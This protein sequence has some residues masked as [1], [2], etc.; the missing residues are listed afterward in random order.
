MRR[1]KTSYYQEV[2]IPI[3]VILYKRN[4][5]ETAQ[6]SFLER[7]LK[8][9]YCLVLVFSLV[10]AQSLLF[11]GFEAHIINVTAHIC[12]Y[13]ETRTMGYWKNHPNVY[14]PLLPQFLV[15]PSGNET[16][17]TQQKVNQVFL[18]YHLS[19]RSK[20]RGQ[21]LAM[22]FNIA[23]FGFG[24]YFDESEDK[25]LNQ[26]VADA[27]NLL[28]DQDTPDSVLEGMKNLLDYLNDL[29]QIKFCSSGNAGSNDDL[30]GNADN[31]DNSDPWN[32]NDPQGNTGNV[33][34]D[35]VINEF[36]PNPVGR[37]NELKPSGEW[38]ELYNKGN[39]IDVAGWVLYDAK[40]NHKLPITGENTNTGF[41]T[42]G[43]GEFLIVYRNGDSDFTLNNVG[44]DTARL[45]N[46]EITKGASLMDSHTYIIDAPEG[47]SFA[48]IPDGSDN[49][50]D[51][52]PTPGEPNILGSKDIVFGPAL[53]EP[54]E[55]TNEEIK[56]E[57]I[58]S[59]EI[60]GSGQAIENSSDNQDTLSPVAEPPTIEATSTVEDK[61][62]A[63]ETQAVDNNSPSTEETSAIEEQP[64]IEQEPVTEPDTNA[65]ES[66][67][68]ETVDGATQENIVV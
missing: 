11:S 57:T 28:L 38:V 60:I 36:L 48:R 61:P 2:K 18:D 32:N 8:I 65:L 27:D 44:G 19:M 33:N 56:N 6:R 17:D 15:A 21:L 31:P 14:L 42:I 34:I 13:S 50:V 20:L 24:E 58:P 16:I 49:W 66:H 43:P 67:D 10:I 45:Y 39:K 7:V 5:K 53:P 12:N 55:E 37:D 40:D 25:T 59:K 9:I 41:T 64:V 68:S 23:N 47:K 1:K 35:I 52:V 51:P 22:K 29:R 26:I 3:R 30:G 63:S 62:T 4:V 46:G 54:D